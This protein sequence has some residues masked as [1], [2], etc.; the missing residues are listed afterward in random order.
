ME[1]TLQEKLQENQRK[2]TDRYTEMQKALDK[3]KNDIELVT[4]FNAALKTNKQR[5]KE[6]IAKLELDVRKEKDRRLAEVEKEKEDVERCLA[7]Y[8]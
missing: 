4:E 1:S 6:K 8:C 3:Q 2:A 5:L 7:F